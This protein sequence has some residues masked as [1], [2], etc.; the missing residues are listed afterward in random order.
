[1]ATRPHTSLFSQAYKDF[2]ATLKL[3]G[4]GAVI[5]CLRAKHKGVPNLCIPSLSTLRHHTRMSLKNAEG[6]AGFNDAAIAR[7]VAHRPAGSEL[8]IHFDART[9]NP[10]IVKEGGKE[11][12]DVDMAGAHHLQQ[13]IYMRMSSFIIHSCL[14]IIIALL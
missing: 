3:L 5:R 12:G 4:G 11:H 8:Q 13:N 7:A 2:F 9:I 14:C 6:G 10:G 1:M